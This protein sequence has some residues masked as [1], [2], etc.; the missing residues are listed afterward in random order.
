MT[1]I[2]GCWRRI[3]WLCLLLAA[4]AGCSPKEEPVE[5]TGGVVSTEDPKE[6]ATPQEELK[7]EE[8]T[9]DLTEAAPQEDA[10]FS[11]AAFLGNS[12]VDG[13][14][15][16]SGLENCDFYCATSMTVTNAD[17]LIAQMA[18]KSYGKIY[19]LLGIN[20]IGYDVDRFTALYQ[21]MLDGIRAQHPETDLYI[22]GLSPVSAEKSTS[23]DL[24][25]MERVEQYNEALYQLAKDNQCYY[26]DLCQ[27]LAGP[28]GFLPAEV[29]SDGVHFAASHYKVWVAYLKT[30]YANQT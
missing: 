12:L 24:F 9:P 23:S 20:E 1:N 18:Q 19:I 22:M 21:E 3:L 13:L 5:E 17:D 30:H 8:F 25:T 14:R 10:F 11:D 6:N 26:V 4:L 15:L 2:N 7:P 29:T 16:Y 27:A 28:D